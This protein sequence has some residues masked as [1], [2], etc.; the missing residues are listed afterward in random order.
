MNVPLEY[1]MGTLRLSTGKL[2]TE[3]EIDK[4]IEVI[5]AAVKKLLD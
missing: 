5:T 4:T 1:A 3:P 2:T